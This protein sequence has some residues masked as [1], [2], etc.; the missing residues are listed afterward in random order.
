[1]PDIQPGGDVLSAAQGRQ[2]GS[3]LF[4]VVTPQ[5]ETRYCLSQ[6]SRPIL[7]SP[8]LKWFKTSLTHS[9]M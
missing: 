5:S 6:K 2:A 4:A 9:I 1:M 8:Y 7:C 3:Q